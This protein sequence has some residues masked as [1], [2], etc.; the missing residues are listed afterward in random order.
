MFTPATN[1]KRVL[2]VMF[3]SK[4][5]SKKEGRCYEKLALNTRR[6]ETTEMVIYERGTAREVKNKSDEEK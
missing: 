6:G 5:K 4:M 1:T 2:L 3:S